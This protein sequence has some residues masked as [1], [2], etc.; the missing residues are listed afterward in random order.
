MAPVVPK[1]YFL[2]GWTYGRRPS[3][4]Y[5]APSGTVT[6][7]PT[8]HQVPCC[9]DRETFLYLA[10]LAHE[11]PWVDHPVVVD[12]RSLR[13]WLDAGRRL[14]NC[15]RHLARV[16]SCTLLV[17]LSGG[18]KRAVAIGTMQPLPAH[19]FL[20]RFSREFVAECADGIPY[21]IETA[22][23]FRSRPALLDLYLVLLG[24][25]HD[26]GE[27]D[28]FTHEHPTYAHLPLPQRIRDARRT[29][30]RR[31]EALRGVLPRAH[32]SMPAKGTSLLVDIGGPKRTAHAGGSPETWK[33]RQDFARMVRGL[34]PE[35]RLRFGLAMQRLAEYEREFGL[36]MQWSDMLEVLRQ[37]EART[38]RTIDS[39]DSFEESLRT[40][41]EKPT[42][43][44]LD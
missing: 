25:V 41:L 24:F 18:I 36:P 2:M 42:D 12:L 30:H 31:V 44:N 22:T 17:P 26:I 33:L 7:V 37:T 10:D 14:D 32:V 35:E 19:R 11:M 27:Y 6:M 5:T 38:A 20:V 40:N 8:G 29:L 34:P 43:P 16:M 23:R 9:A 1:L 21:S 15:A 3:N 13:G 4:P 28:E 39:V